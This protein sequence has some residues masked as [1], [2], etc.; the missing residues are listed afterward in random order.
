[1][2][3]SDEQNATSHGL[4]FNSTDAKEKPLSLSPSARHMTGI[5]N[6]G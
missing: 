5:K 3:K 1:M 2:K 6:R 4:Q